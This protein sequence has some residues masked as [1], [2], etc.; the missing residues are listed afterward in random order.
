MRLLRIVLFGIT[1]YFLG[2][3]LG[4]CCKEGFAAPIYEQVNLNSNNTTVFR[5]LVTP[6]STTDVLLK[7]ADLV[8]KREDKTYPL[9]LVMDSPGGDIISGLSFIDAVKTIPNLRTIT[10]FS[11]SM[12]S[13][14][15]EAIPGS[16]LITPSG[17]IMFHRAAGQLSGQF[18]VGELE[19]RLQE[20]KDMVRGMESTNAE[21]LGITL[22]QYKAK[23]VNEY[24]LH[25]NKA[26]LD[27]VV[28]KIVDIVCSQ[29]LIQSRVETEVEMLFSDTT[30]EFSG[31]P[32]FRY[33]IVN[34]KNAKK[35][36]SF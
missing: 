31:C 9:Y 35:V 13:A 5:G 20:A 34:K 4:T 32:T 19:S 27:K 21:R 26:V 1:G 7:L 15:V 33:P 3:V 6:T 28:D 11:A 36:L 23:A 18:E 25:S 29:E 14:I 24:W 17:L 8:E 2:Y 22:A 10:I 12:A 30:L 16:R